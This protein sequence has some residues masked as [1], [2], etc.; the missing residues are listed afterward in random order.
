MSAVS[1][2]RHAADIQLGPAQLASIQLTRGALGAVGGGGGGGGGWIGAASRAVMAVATAPF[3]ELAGGLG[4]PGR[5]S[6]P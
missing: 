4:P 3:A 2:G 1:W 5:L 6:A